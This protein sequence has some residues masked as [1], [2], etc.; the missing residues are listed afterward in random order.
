[1]V[2]YEVWRWGA[3][4]P[5]ASDSVLKRALAK[6]HRARKRALEKEAPTHQPGQYLF[7]IRR[8]DC[9]P[10]TDEERAVVGRCS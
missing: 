6:L 2:V 7:E 5:C 8:S 9:L 10:L 3:T 1:M 4:R